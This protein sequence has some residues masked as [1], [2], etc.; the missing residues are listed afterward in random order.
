MIS[1]YY[2]GECP[3]CTK[4]VRMVRLQ[5]AD[6]VRLVNL[7]EDEDLRARFAAEG[8][9]LDGGMVVD[10]RGTRFSGDKAVAYM[11]ALSTPSDAFNR[12]NRWIF[13]NATLA[14]ALYP[15][16]RAGRWVAL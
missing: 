7:R 5:R 16:M 9:D 14:A 10:D 3:F 15:L 1:V 2:D 4:Y 13:S 12:L 11:A 8:F 6:E